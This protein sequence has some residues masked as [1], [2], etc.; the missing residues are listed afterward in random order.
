MKISDIA[1]G[2]TG[3]VDK[4]NLGSTWFNR[5]GHL[6]FGLMVLA[7]LLLGLW[8]ARRRKTLA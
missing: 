8:G 1:F 3:G 6:P 2:T 7:S 4:L 5:L